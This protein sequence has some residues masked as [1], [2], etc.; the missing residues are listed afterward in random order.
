MRALGAK[1]TLSDGDFDVAKL[2]ARQLAADH[3]ECVF[4][5]DGAEDAIAK[6]LP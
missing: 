3:A 2:N 4:V 5:E 6:A 1:V